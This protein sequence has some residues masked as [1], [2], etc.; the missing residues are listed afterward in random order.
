M[1]KDILKCMAQRAKKRLISNGEKL[2]NEIPHASKNGNCKIKSIKN[3]DEKFS[4]KVRTLL[5]KEEEIINPIKLL[6]DE[7]YFNKLDENGKERYLL[8]TIDNFTRLKNEIEKEKE[9]S[10]SLFD[11]AN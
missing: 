5:E 11:K 3:I 6:M 1:S 7:N 2:P 10:F 8:K 4:E 9:N